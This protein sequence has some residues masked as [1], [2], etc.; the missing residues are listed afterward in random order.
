MHEA[1]EISQEYLEIYYDLMHTIMD[2]RCVIFKTKKD[3]ENSNK[4][5][6][7]CRKDSKLSMPN[8]RTA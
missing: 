6:R 2:S 8:I 3:P 7:K 5:R 1:I 4:I